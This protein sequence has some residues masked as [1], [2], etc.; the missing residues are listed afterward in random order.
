MGLEE[1]EQSP[2]VI[3]SEQ[4]EGS[5]GY[6]KGCEYELSYSLRLVLAHVPPIAVDSAAAVT[7]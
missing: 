2:A 3:V 5:Q 6:E 4:L 1:V 7:C